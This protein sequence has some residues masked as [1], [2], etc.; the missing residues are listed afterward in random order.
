[1]KR[2]IFLMHGYV[3]VITLLQ[4]VYLHKV[5]CGGENKPQLFIAQLR[6]SIFMLLH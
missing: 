6:G 4:S 5:S 3:S 1:M 2:I